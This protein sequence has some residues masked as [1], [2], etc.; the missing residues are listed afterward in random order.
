MQEQY[1]SSEGGERNT[2]EYHR[3]RANK[4]GLGAAAIAAAY[5][6]SDGKDA[7][8]AHTDP[9]A[10]KH[11]IERA[12]TAEPGKLDIASV[13]TDLENGGDP[14][15][16]V[17]DLS[18]SSVGAPEEGIQVVGDIEELKDDIGSSIVDLL[19][20]HKARRAAKTGAAPASEPEDANTA[21]V[22]HILDDPDKRALLETHD[23][24][25]NTQE[26][27]AFAKR[28]ADMSEGGLKTKAEEFIS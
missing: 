24:T 2:K 8:A 27:V 7:Q 16:D 12:Q 20:R 17:E 18:R 1:E 25:D 28:L 19:W 9:A 11:S 26:L 5:G 3:S 15:F 14:V 22:A 21:L 4:V 10:D 6:M 23:P 13:L